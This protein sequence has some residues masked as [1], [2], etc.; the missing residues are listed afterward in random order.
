MAARFWVGGTG[1]WTDTAHWSTT[2][3]GGGGSAAPVAGDAVTFDANSGATATV[4]VDTAPQACTSIVINKSDLTLILSFGLTLTGAMTLTT[5]TLNTNGKT[6]SFGSLLCAGLVSRT[7]TLG[8][9]AITITTGGG[10][11]LTTNTITNLTWTANTATITFSA[12]NAG[13]FT[14]IFNVNGTSMVFSGGGGSS[15]SGASGTVTMGGLTITGT[16]V[17][18]DLFTI[19]CNQLTCTN[20]TINGQSVT[21]RVFV[22]SNQVGTARVL[23]C[24]TVTAITNADFQDVTASGPT[25]FTGTSLGDALGNTNITFDVAVPQTFAGGT[26]NW[27]DVTA[28]TSRVPLPQDNVT[29]ATTTAGTLTADMPRLG[30]SLDFTGFTRTFSMGSTIAKFFGD[31]TLASGMTCSGTNAMQP[32]GR[33]AANKITTATAVM[34]WGFTFTAGGGTY[35]LQDNLTTTGTVAWTLTSGIVDLN[36]KNVRISSFIDGGGL[37]RQIKLGNGTLTL[38][39]NGTVWSVVA[40]MTITPGTAIIDVTDTSGSTKTFAGAGLTYPTLRHVATGAGGL[41]I[42]GANTFAALDLECSTARTITL[43]ANASQTVTGILGLTLKGASGQNLSLASS[44][45]G[46]RASIIAQRWPM[47]TNPFVTPSTDIRIVHRQP[48]PAITI[49]DPAIA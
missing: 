38:A 13:W 12:A 35:T 49:Q 1:N 39:G 20:L 45:P 29:I 25:P 32:S 42:S 47:A 23:A 16:A 24:T 19:G 44:T 11:N 18:S 40:A 43:P 31:L 21:N 6:C 48:R 8:A 41:T 33:G 10:S 34:T 46:T 28:W 14:T 30:K 7:L 5:G 3:G 4:T 22:V 17:K 27:S 2:S 36:D 37:L 9:S 26:K 15:I